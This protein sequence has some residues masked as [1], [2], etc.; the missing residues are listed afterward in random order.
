MAGDLIVG[1]DPSSKTLALVGRNPTTKGFV[2]KKAVL[3][4]RHTPDC[5]LEALHACHDFLESMEGLGYPMSRNLFLEAPVVGRGGTRSTLVQ[6]YV[7]GVVQAA[8]LQAGFTVHLVNVSTWKKDV[9]GHGHA[10]KEA[11]AGVI[12]DKWPAMFRQHGGDQDL[13]D[14]AALCIYGSRT[15]RR[16]RLVA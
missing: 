14:A 16:S 2:V 9:C 6:A 4:P 12:A 3:G 11:V 1:V 15:L 10:G 5:C 7:N 8:F 13:L